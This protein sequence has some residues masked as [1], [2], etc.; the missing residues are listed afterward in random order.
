M[1][2]TT[3]KPSTTGPSTTGPSTTG[4][5]DSMR[6]RDAPMILM[7]HGIADVPEDPNQLCV[8]PARFAE[9]LTWLDRKSVV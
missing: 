2:A 8:S 1:T 7:Y 3:T 6:L 9:Q 4:Q 5:P